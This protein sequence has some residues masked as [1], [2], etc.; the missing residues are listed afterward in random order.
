MLKSTS[1]QMLRPP[2]RFSLATCVVIAV[3]GCSLFGGGDRAAV[4]PPAPVVDAVEAVETA[5]V[6]AV[7]PEPNSATIKMLAEA[8]AAVN[9]AGADAGEAKILLEQARASADNGDDLGAQR[10]ARESLIKAKNSGNDKL[11]ALA[12]KEL[13]EVKTYTNLNAQQYEKLRAAENALVNNRGES[14]YTLLQD[15]NSQLEVKVAAAAP[16]AP[17]PA[18]AE[19]APAGTTVAA[20][21]PPKTSGLLRYTVKR[22]DSLWKISGYDEI[23]GNPYQWPLIYKANYRIIKNPD[24]IFPKQVFKIIKNPR[25]RQVELAVRYANKRPLNRRDRAAADAAYGRRSEAEK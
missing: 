23:Y 22:G 11:V 14:A 21:K 19:N 20:T 17:A 25:L 8:Q 18:P 6:A 4:Y 16:P 7:A 3:G 12:K 5:A 9:V 24:L 10:L 1:S 2:L 15:L 13:S